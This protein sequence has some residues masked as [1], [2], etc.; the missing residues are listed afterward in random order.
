MSDHFS[1]PKRARWTPVRRFAMRVFWFAAVAFSANVGGA[2][3]LH[4]LSDVRED[5]VTTQLNCV[6]WIDL[7][8]TPSAPF[9]AF[10]DTMFSFLSACTPENYALARTVQ[11]SVV[12]GDSIWVHELFYSNVGGTAPITAIARSD[13]TITFR[14]E[15]GQQ[16]R[17]FYW[18]ELDGHQHGAGTGFLKFSLTASGPSGATVLDSLGIYLG[19]RYE[20]PG[21]YHEQFLTLHSGDYTLDAHVYGEQGGPIYG[22]LWVKLRLY[23]A[24]PV[25]P[26][27]WGQV[28]GL[29]R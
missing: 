12:R 4:P 19:G 11:E 10:N 22:D 26:S 13:A 27:T 14:I 9:A 16:S 29:Y 21:A 24:T 5:H 25:A 6:D 2:Q 8:R 1:R 20:D 23:A 15:A 17:C 7:D 3:S 18:A 28:K